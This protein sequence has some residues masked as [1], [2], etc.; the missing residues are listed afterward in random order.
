MYNYVYQTSYYYV[1]IFIFSKAWV[2]SVRILVIHVYDLPR[3]CNAPARWC[4][5]R[6]R[7]VSAAGESWCPTADWC[8]R[9]CSAA[10]CSAQ[11]VCCVS[12]SWRERSACHQRV[13]PL[14]DS[15]KSITLLYFCDSNSA[16]E[17]SFHITQ[18]RTLFV[19]TDFYLT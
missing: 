2:P 1:Y 17:Y 4:T 13:V 9:S 19:L 18:S 14:P 16:L 15:G 7:R 8:W 11:S 10:T 3:Y 12:R 5:S 6:G